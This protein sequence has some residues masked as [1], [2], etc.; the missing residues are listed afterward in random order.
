MVEAAPVT[1]LLDA[2]HDPAPSPSEVHTW[3]LV[4]AEGIKYSPLST[5]LAER[6]PSAK[7]ARSASY[8]WTST[9]ISTPRF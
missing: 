5:L 4:P 8:P 3:P 6:V 7:S 1:E 9:P 2:C